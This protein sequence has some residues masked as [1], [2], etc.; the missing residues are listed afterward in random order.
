MGTIIIILLIVYMC[1]RYYKPRYEK[2][3][4]EKMK[5][6]YM[7]IPKYWDKIR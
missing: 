4:H 2:R 7:F 1:Y 5:F 3:Y 6:R